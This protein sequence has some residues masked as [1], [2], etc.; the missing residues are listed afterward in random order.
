MSTSRGGETE[1]TYLYQL[2]E[3]FISETIASCLDNL[4]WKL[5]RNGEIVQSFSEVY[6]AY[7]QIFQLQIPPTTYQQRKDLCSARGNLHFHKGK[8]LQQVIN[9]AGYFRITY[10]KEIAFT[11]GIK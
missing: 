11:R 4:D 10:D 5:K 2:F 3:G 1:F 7:K 6:T 9:Q 8:Y